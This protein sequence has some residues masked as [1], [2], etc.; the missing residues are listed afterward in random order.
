MRIGVIDLTQHPQP[1]MAGMPRAGET[2]AAWLA[3]ALP[4]ADFVQHRVADGAPLPEAEGC[5]GL[6]VSGSEK[7]VYD[8]VPWMDP[9]RDLLLAARAAETPVFGICFGHQIMAET[10]GG[11]AEKSAAGMVIGARRFESGSGAVPAH[12]WHQ[13]QV[14]RVPPGARVTAWADYCPIGALDYPHRAASVQYHPEY[15]R[16]GI[17]ALLDRVTGHFVSEAQVK[18][19]RESMQGAEVA[20]DLATGQAAALFRGTTDC[21]GGRGA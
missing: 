4:E 13:D 21:G 5:D 19:A 3:P 10:Y 9:L 6:I 16:A 18:A 7:G 2:I 12:V 14:T 17:D 8:Q 15:T 11:T 1:L 20:P